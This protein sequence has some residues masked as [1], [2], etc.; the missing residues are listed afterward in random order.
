MTTK[1]K[2]AIQLMEKSPLSIFLLSLLGVFAGFSGFYLIYTINRI[3]A[4]LI[5]DQLAY[6]NTHY[7]IVLLITITCFVISRRVLSKQVINLSQKLYWNIRLKIS[8]LLVR[9]NYSESQELKNDI[10]S[11]IHHDAITMMSGSNVI[12]NLFTNLILVVSS[13]IYMAFLNIQLFA[14]CMA[15]IVIGVTIYQ[16]GARR[17]TMYF[18]TSRK[19]ESVFLKHFDA[20]FY[21][22][23][24]INLAPGKGDD[25]NQFK[26]Q[27]ISKQSIYSDTRGYMGYLKSMILGQLVFYILIGSVLLYLGF[28][29]HIE[30]ST[31]VNFSF[32][33]LFMLGPIENIMLSIPVFGK[34]IISFS[35]MMKI[36][37]KLDNDYNPCV[38]E[39][40]EKIR[41]FSGLKITGLEYHYPVTDKFSMG[42]VDLEVWPSEIIFIYGGNGSGKSTFIKVLLQLYRETAGEIELNKQ[43]IS[44]HN[45]HQYRN[46]F[47]AVFSDFYLFDEFYGIHDV[48]PAVI[49][50]YLIL[51]EVEKK[52]SF[53]NGK[54]S[55]TDLSGGQRK[56]LAIISAILEN[57]PILILDEWAADQD[58]E[59]RSKFYNTIL[60]IL[61]RKGITVI[62]ITH[63]DVYYHC[64]DR[65]FKMDFGKMKEV[66]IKEKI[67]CS[68]L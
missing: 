46:N 48:S 65:I 55:T 62:A 56:R 67:I 8:S 39:A 27:D 49:Q 6:S 38:T 44:D 40:V 15:A 59:F 13:I 17:N 58:P 11:A 41:P 18:N 4:L 34:A 61:K 33:V 60:P 28:L 14:F 43:Y 51:F 45:R 31:I 32:L 36:V 22:A 50:E 52:V 7:T 30:N 66:T 47:A 21:G 19:L 9:S 53:I 16:L 63:D 20:L 57:K 25:I 1:F 68:R 64:A 12:I 10:Y 3:T 29:F 26:I 42:P 24:E 35:K 5:K 2:D 23:K 37:N 54:F